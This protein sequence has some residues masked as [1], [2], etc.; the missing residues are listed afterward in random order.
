[1]L[2]CTDVTVTENEIKFRIF[3]STFGDLLCN[4]LSAVM[5]GVA[6]GRFGLAGLHFAARSTA[7]L[8]NS[9]ITWYPLSGFVPPDLEGP[10]A[11]ILIGRKS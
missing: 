10:T 9:Q 11:L 5:A 4:F 6:I 8:R 3:T 7:S 2:L 1:M